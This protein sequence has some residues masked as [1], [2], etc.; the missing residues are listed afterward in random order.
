M[1][2]APHSPLGRMPRALPN[3]ASWV[4]SS[5]QLDP[6]AGSSVLTRLGRPA[7]PMHS[8]LLEVCSAL[9]TKDSE[10]THTHTYTQAHMH[11]HAHM[12]THAH[13]CTHMHMHAH[14][15]VLTHAQTRARTHVHTHAPC[16]CLHSHAHT[17]SPADTRTH[18]H[19]H[20]CT[21]AHTYKHAHT[22]T[23]TP[24][25]CALWSDYLTLSWERPA[26]GISE[27]ARG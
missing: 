2:G 17:C 11:T 5:G 4:P 26:S 23:H 1:P 15:H 8:G 7:H 16:T 12:R 9:P 24:H 14:A 20:T 22:H 3:A 6:G 19:T 10:H 18:A 21:R 25:T 13:M 27:H